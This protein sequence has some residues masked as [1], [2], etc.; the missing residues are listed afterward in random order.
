M[1]TVLLDGNRVDISPGATLGDLLPGHDPALSVAVIRPGTTS[2][3]ETRQFLLKT[4]AGEIVVEVSGG[5]HAFSMSDIPLDLTVRWEDRQALS[6]GHFSGH[7]T[8]SRRPYRYER[9]DLILGCGGYDSSRSLLIFARRTHSADYGASADGGRLGQVISGRGVVDRLGSGDR[10][11][12]VEPVISFSESVDALTTNDLKYPVTDGME[13]ISRLNIEVQGYDNVT[14]DIFNDASES[15]EFL[16]LALR[17][18][19]ITCSQRLS[20]HIRCDTLAGTA[21][22]YEVGAPRREGSVL[23]RTSGKNQGS[24]YIYTEDLP[25]SLAHTVVGQVIHGIEIAKIARDGESFGVSVTPTKFDLIGISLGEATKIAAEHGVVITPDREGDDRIV[26]VQDPAHTLDVLAQKQVGVRTVPDS[27]VID[28]T[29][30]DHAAPDTCRIFREITGLKYHPVGKMPLFFAF[31]DVYL[32]Q[33]KI[34]KTTNIKPE[35]TPDDVVPAGILA[36]TNESRKGVGMVGV[37]TSENSEF[38]PTSEPFS[39]T[40]VMGTVVD[41]QKLSVLQEGDM[42]YFREVLP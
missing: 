1:A 18:G 34:P 26:I 21:V 31:D 37:R 12:G 6:L 17:S 10:I 11:L 35:N 13:I 22:P 40:N 28:I 2:S 14:G 5:E 15:A 27:Q 7:F 41:T 16:L 23:M 42:V 30:D 24:I 36:M 4:T 39:G 20:T 8:S 38:G 32:F 19:K 9:G 29:L 25:R 33:T 3:S